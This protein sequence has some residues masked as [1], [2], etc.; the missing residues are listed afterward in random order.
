[1]VRDHIPPISPEL[2]LAQRIL[3]EK[4]AAARAE[5]LAAG[6]PVDLASQPR[7]FAPQT[8]TRPTEVETP[9]LEPERPAAPQPAPPW[10]ESEAGALAG[11]SAAPRR[12]DRGSQAETAVSWEMKN[13]LA[14]I[15][16]LRRL[17]ALGQPETA[18]SNAAGWL[19]PLP[20]QLHSAPGPQKRP[21]ISQ[22]GHQSGSESA[23]EGIQGEM[24]RVH[25]DLGLAAKKAGHVGAFQTWLIIC[26]LDQ[27]RG[28][29]DEADFLRQASEKGS[30]YRFSKPTVTYANARRQARR[31]VADCIDAGFLHR[32]EN[33]R[34]FRTGAAKLAGALGLARIDCQPVDL[35]LEKVTGSAGAFNAAC[36]LP[37]TPAATT[38]TIPSAG[39]R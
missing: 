10:V 19:P 39:K 32:A 16:Q 35:P 14:R 33:G 17:N 21:L 24:V 3:L 4:R 34:L 22:S 15:N 27:G 31:R 29:V 13:A 11:A 9:K 36:T 8:A 7:K 37:G 12:P 18:V 5:R 28:D 23:S 26:H 2:E 38:P 20:Q 25:P 6:L 1:V 30:I